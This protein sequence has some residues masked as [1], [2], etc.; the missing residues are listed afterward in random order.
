MESQPPCPGS[1]DIILAAHRVS[2]EPR[3]TMWVSPVGRREAEC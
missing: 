2:L 3:E 1:L